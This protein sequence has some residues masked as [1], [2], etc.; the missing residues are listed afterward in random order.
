MIPGTYEIVGISG[1][2]RLKRSGSGRSGHDAGR[3]ATLAVLSHIYIFSYLRPDP[4]IHNL[5]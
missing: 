1:Y 4:H 2:K 5:P 3:G